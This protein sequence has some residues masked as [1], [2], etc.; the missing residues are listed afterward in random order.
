MGDVVHLTKDYA[1]CDQCPKNGKEC[2]ESADVCL[3]LELIKQIAGQI[4]LG[5]LGSLEELLLSLTEDSQ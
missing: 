4:R 5:K 3:A 2:P 1:I